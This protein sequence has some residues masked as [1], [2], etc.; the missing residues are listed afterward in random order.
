MSTHLESK[1]SFADDL[2]ATIKRQA[3]KQN[4]KTDDNEIAF[5]EVLKEVNEGLKSAYSVSIKVSRDYTRSP[6]LLAWFDDLLHNW[7]NIHS[8][9]RFIGIKTPNLIVD[10][11]YIENLKGNELELFRVFSS[12]SHNDLGLVRYPDEELSG[13]DGFDVIPG[14]KDGSYFN[15]LLE[16]LEKRLKSQT[17]VNQI[18]KLSELNSWKSWE[19][20]PEL[21]EKVRKTQEKPKS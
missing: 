19:Q 17:I 2:L 13:I 18:L 4:Q 12:P 6:N 5:F 3:Q 16:I 10:S 15:E 11:Y 14:N 8:S 9:T 21:L 20:A 7:D 1:Q